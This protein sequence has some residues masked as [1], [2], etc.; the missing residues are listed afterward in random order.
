MNKP[1]NA[2]EVRISLDGKDLVLRSSLRAARAVSADQDGFVGALQRLARFDF[3]AFV[4]IIAVGI[5]KDASDIEDAV[6]EAGLET[7]VDPVSKYVGY[8]MRGGREAKK[9]GEGD[10][11]PKGKP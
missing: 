1:V 2:G 5:G 10:E 7:L 11:A 9:A 3:D 4:S 6:Y 8:L